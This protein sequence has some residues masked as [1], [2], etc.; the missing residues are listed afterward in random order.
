MSRLFQNASNRYLVNS[1]ACPISAPPFTLSC[2]ARS[3]AT[4]DKALISLGKTGTTDRHLLYDGNSTGVTAFS[5]SGGT[6]G[7]STSG[8]SEHVGSVTFDHCAGVWASA[9][10]RKVYRNG[11]G[12]TANTTS[13]SIT[14]MDRIY[15]GAYYNNGVQTGFSYSGHICEVA[16]WNVALTDE[17]IKSLSDGIRATSVR[18]QS[19]VGYWPIFGRATDEEDWVGTALLT[20]TNSAAAATTHS[21]VIVPAS[22]AHLRVG[23]GGG[24]GG[25]PARP[26]VFFIT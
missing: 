25:G 15:V 7:Q 20:N 8:S 11:V 14:G 6:V 12:F 9:T 5:G 16:A 4:N 18:P 3:D 24:G 19:L 1:A 10:S 22:Y 2:F 13:V 21:R 17:E 23:P 26:Y